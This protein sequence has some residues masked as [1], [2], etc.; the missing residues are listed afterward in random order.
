MRAS[1]GLIAYRTASISWI[2]RE[3]KAS[4]FTA[5]PGGFEA[6]GLLAICAVDAI[7]CRKARNSRS[8]ERA[9]STAHIAKKPRMARSGQENFLGG[10]FMLDHSSLVRQQKV[11]DLRDEAEEIGREPVDAQ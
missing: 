1:P 9:A 5:D 4:I 2:A 8:D 6:E 3:A 11:D 10:A 7:H